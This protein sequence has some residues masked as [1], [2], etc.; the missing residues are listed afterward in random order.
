MSLGMICGENWTPEVSGGGATSQPTAS[1][2]LQG[3]VTTR[4]S[5]L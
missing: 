4:H 1:W 5:A 2:E 3:N